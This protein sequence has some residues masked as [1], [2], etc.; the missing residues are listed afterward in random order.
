M[1]PKDE[2]EEIDDSDDVFPEDQ[3]VEPE[4]LRE[5]VSSFLFCLNDRITL[6]QI[7]GFLFCLMLLIMI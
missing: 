6:A 3:D 1:K 7:V 5:K 2:E 4:I